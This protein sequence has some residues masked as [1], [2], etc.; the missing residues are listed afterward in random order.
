MIMSQ[1]LGRHTDAI[2]LLRALKERYNTKPLNA[3]R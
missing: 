1:S 2:A 3:M